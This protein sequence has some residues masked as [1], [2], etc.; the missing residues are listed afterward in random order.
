MHDFRAFDKIQSTFDMDDFENQPPTTNDNNIQAKKPRKA[1]II[2]PSRSTFSLDNFNTGQLGAFQS[3]PL[4]LL[5]MIFGYLPFESLA[6]IVSATC[7]S[8]RSLFTYAPLWKSVHGV[9]AAL[10]VLPK[11]P[12][13][14]VEQFSMTGYPVRAKA[15][16]LNRCLKLIA[17]EQSQNLTSL[18]LSGSTI[19]KKQIRDCQPLFSSS[20]ERL[21][22][23]NISRGVDY[24]FML[25]EKPFS[26]VTHL[27]AL[28]LSDALSL[29]AVLGALP[30][31]CFT[32]LTF[33]RVGLFH[34]TFCEVFQGIHARLTNLAR[35]E[36]SNLRLDDLTDV[37]W[38]TLARLPH[39]SLTTLVV[40]GLGPKMW[41]EKS[42]SD[43][44]LVNH[45]LSN[46][47]SVFPSIKN[48]HLSRGP[49][50]KPREERL[51]NFSP[52]V[53][54]SLSSSLEKLVLCHWKLSAESLY[55]I[56]AAC[57][58]L[59]SCKLFHCLLEDEGAA[60]VSEE[61]DIVEICE[62]S[63]D[64]VRVGKRDLWDQEFFMMLGQGLCLPHVSF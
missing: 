52:L 41:D 43:Q 49:F 53:L 25:E 31:S 57:P 32:G 42:Q 35:L 51:S 34:G 46:I 12:I 59:K 44:N 8:W 39:L 36:I 4:E 50:K 20:L 54:T 28:Y 9:E 33:L 61:I 62:S 40:A 30:V 47:F 45:L 64:S 24:A 26:N 29:F 48:L 21:V 63:L 56:Q 27:K 16:S 10:A 7:K 60:H 18:T 23:H 37:P 19:S 5:V 17:K 1:K 22:L 6:R 2:V 14:S 38:D 55:T 3:I 58:S 13:E 15:A 11:V